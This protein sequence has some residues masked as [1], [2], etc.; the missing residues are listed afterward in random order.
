MT[1]WTWS[2]YEATPDDVIERLIAQ[3]NARAAEEQAQHQHPEG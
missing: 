3:E 1:G 2:D